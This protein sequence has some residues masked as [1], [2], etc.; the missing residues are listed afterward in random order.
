[1]LDMKFLAGLFEHPYVDVDEA[2]R[3]VE[4]AGRMAPSRSRRRGD[5]SSCSK[6]A[7][8]ALPLDRAKLRTLAV[9]GPNAKGVRL[10]GYSAD[11]G[12]RR[13]RALPASRTRPGPA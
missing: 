8:D 4:H 5:R 12:P 9:I 3:A 7:T 6:T 1:M 2:E 11:P 10:G 13:G